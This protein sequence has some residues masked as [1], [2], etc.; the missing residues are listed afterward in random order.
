MFPRNLATK[1]RRR[2]VCWLHTR[3]GAHLFRRG[4]LGGARRHFLRAI[5]AWDAAS[6]P[7][8]YLYRIYLYERR[9]R[10]A[11]EELDRARQLNPRL[12]HLALLDPAL[13]R[14]APFEPTEAEH[15]S[16]AAYLWSLA[17]TPEENECPRHCGNIETADQSEVSRRR[18]SPA[19]AGAE[20]VAPSEPPERVQLGDCRDG[21]EYE[22]FR[23]LGPIQPREL[24][25]LDWSTLLK[26]LLDQDGG[27]R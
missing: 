9:F 16:D 15:R 19:V 14:S 5:E 6:Q 22:H 17:E 18:E 12:P 21:A 8:L 27:A 11:I 20:R 4:D 23:R 25:E 2:L 7:H 3:A 1:L 13:L 24:A 10:K 26:K